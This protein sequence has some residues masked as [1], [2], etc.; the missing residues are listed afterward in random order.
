MQPKQANLI[1]FLPSNRRLLLLPCLSFN[2][3]REIK[4][5]LVKLVHAHI[6]IL[7]AAGVSLAVGI[8][9]HRVQR[10]EV[11]TH[12]P[13]LL[14]EDLVVEAGLKFSL[15]RR[16]GGYIHCSLPASKDHEVLLWG[17]RGGIKGSIGNIG[18]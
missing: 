9:G 5:R 7:A 1:A 2:L 8:R 13:N 18:F 4:V 15:P 6:S 3:V 12:A 10:P 17:D 14:L 16:R 11:P